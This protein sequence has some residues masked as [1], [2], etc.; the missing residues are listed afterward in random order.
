VAAPA[1]EAVNPIGSGDAFAAGMAAAI[2]RGEGVE[3]QLRLGTACAVANAMTAM[4]GTVVRAD[5][6]RL[7]RE[8]GVTRG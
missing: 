5:V 3:G 7:A 8:V 2:A 6:E 1:V 4:A